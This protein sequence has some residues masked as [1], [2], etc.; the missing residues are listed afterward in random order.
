ADAGAAVVA[1]QQGHGRTGRRKAQRAGRAAQARR[2]RAGDQVQHGLHHHRRL[3]GRKTVS[4]PGHRVVHQMVQSRHGVDLQGRRQ[5]AQVGD[6]GL[7]GRGGGHDAPQHR[8][9]QRGQQALGR[10]ADAGRTEAA[11]GQQGDGRI[12]RAERERED[13]V[14]QPRLHHQAAPGAA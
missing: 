14:H 11:E 6:E 12:G 13:L 3:G 8:V 5:G 4:Q 9:H 7:G 1:Q 10:R 2:R